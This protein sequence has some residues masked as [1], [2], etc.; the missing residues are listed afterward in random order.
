MTLAVARISGDRIAIASDTLL[1]EHGLPLPVRKGVI[2]S[3][4][5]PGDLCATFANSPELAERDFGRFVELHPEGAGFSDV[6]SFFENSSRQTGNDYLLAFSR[7]PR[8]VKIADGRRCDSI[9]KTLWIGDADAY[10]RFR[11]AELRISE[12]SLAGRAINAALFADEITASPASD[13]YSAMREVASDL[14]IASV[15]GFVCV[16]SN[17]DPGFRHSVYSDMLFNWPDGRD[18]NFPID[19]NAQIDFGSSGENEEYSVSQ[20]STGFLGLNIVGFYLLK[21]R[22]AFLFHGQP[23]GLPTRCI[24]LNDTAPSELAERL[25]EALGFDPRWLLTIM[26]AA[27]GLK[28]TT[29]RWPLRTHGPSGAGLTLLCHAN[30]FP[31]TN[32]PD[33]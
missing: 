25:S 28:H 2:K 6:V 11:K 26:A 20:I 21:A 32:S 16:I 10:Q 19:M 31:P 13:L 14:S 29:E 5:L 9:S 30:T 3:C 22:K 12:R 4:M 17:R 33:N 15:G 18:A 24:V 23:N 1:T 27:P 8:I 7:I